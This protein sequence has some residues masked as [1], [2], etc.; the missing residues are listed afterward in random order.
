M[1]EGELEKMVD[2]ILESDL[3][4]LDLVYKELYKDIENIL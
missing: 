3:P 4:E 2:E 1:S